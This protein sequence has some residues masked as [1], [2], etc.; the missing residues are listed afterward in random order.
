MYLCQ[1]HANKNKTNQFLIFHHEL[2]TQKHAQQKTERQR[3]GITEIFQ[4]FK[5]VL[6]NVQKSNENTLLNPL[7]LHHT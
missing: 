5:M 3:K 1:L 4:S 6:I 7:Q 2:Q